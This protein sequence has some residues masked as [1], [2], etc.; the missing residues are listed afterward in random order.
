MNADYTYDRDTDQFVVTLDDG[1]E[2]CRTRAPHRSVHKLLAGWLVEKINRG[3]MVRSGSGWMPA[4][5][6]DAVLARHFAT[7]LKAGELVGMKLDSHS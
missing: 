3:S 1:T 6:T 4:S 2:V 5:Q 7:Y